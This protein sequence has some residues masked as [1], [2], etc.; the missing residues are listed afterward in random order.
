MFAHKKAHKVFFYSLACAA[1]LS[2][3]KRAVRAA[4]LERAILCVLGT[5]HNHLDHARATTMHA[6]QLIYKGFEIC[7]QGWRV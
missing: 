3:Q 6:Q 2:W 7:A 4:R 1:V 5:R